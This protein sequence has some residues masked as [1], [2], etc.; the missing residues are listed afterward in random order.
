MVDVLRRTARSMH[1]QL[2]TPTMYGI[3]PHARII[4]DRFR[5]AVGWRAESEAEREE[6]AR[7]QR[8]LCLIWL[9]TFVDFSGEQE[10][11]SNEQVHMNSIEMKRSFAMCV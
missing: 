1:V 11:A 10:F 7:K 5:V 4:E 3:K 2:D 9:L 6:R 8:A